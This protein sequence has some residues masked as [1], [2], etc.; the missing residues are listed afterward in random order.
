MAGSGISM[1]PATSNSEDEIHRERV[2]VAA[3]IARQ[4]PASV[5]YGVRSFPHKSLAGDDA[6]SLFVVS[7]PV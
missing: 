5:R 7:K 3:G 4:K 6:H 1:T 2:M